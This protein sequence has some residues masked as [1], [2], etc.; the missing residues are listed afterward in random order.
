MPSVPPPQTV[1]DEPSGLDP[2]SLRRAPSL[3][4][5]LGAIL[6]GV[7]LAIV[8]TLVIQIIGSAFGSSVSHPSPA[9]TL[10]GQA[11]FEIAFVVSALWFSYTQGVLDPK[12]F[13][14]RRVPWRLAVSA[15]VL[16]AITYYGLGLVYQQLLN[17]HAKD[18]LP[19][20]F[21]INQHTA[22][23]VGAA[24]YVCVVA[25]ICE[26]F[27]F[28]GFLLNILKRMRVVVGG[29]DIGLWVAVLITS[30]LFGLAHLG[31]A[32]AAFLVPLGFLGL[33]LCI[34]RLR[35]RSLYPCMALHSI[36][37]SVAFGAVQVHWN[38]VEI[39]ALA[40]G[41]LCVI[42]AITGPLAD[43]RSPTPAP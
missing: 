12:F 4:I 9:V 30:I 42:T 14:Y 31:S 1:P 38:V 23:L 15:V 20:D 8:S 32:P 2:G 26:E 13:G 28:R 43:V 5:A 33:V 36:N 6:L 19:K 17:L 16:G 7:G 41:S 22:A 27:F 3:G 37:N 25:P 11:A 24:V 39:V 18:K 29:R 21:G 35:T 34:I 40:A 10:L